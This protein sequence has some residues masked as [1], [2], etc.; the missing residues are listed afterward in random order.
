MAV[1]VITN[2]INLMVKKSSDFDFWTKSF[3]QKQH[4][5]FFVKSLDFLNIK[6][7]PK[8]HFLATKSNFETTFISSTFKVEEIKV[9][10]EFSFCG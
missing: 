3:G 8:V 1:I 10:S 2:K 5:D 9:V 7:G 4:L 6:N